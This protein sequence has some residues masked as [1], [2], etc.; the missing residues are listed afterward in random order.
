[1]RQCILPYFF[2][3][4]LWCVSGLASAQTLSPQQLV[5]EW[6]GFQKADDNEKNFR[7]ASLL[8]G[9][10]DV[11]Q[12]QYLDSIPVTFLPGWR[13]AKAS[14]NA[15]G[16]FYA[17]VPGEIQPARLL[18]GYLHPGRNEA[19]VF[20]RKLKRATYPDSL[21]V[22]VQANQDTE[23]DYSLTF[24]SG[25]EIL[26]EIPDV[27]MFV[28]SERL[29]RN[30]D[31]VRKKELSDSLAIK[32]MGLMA[33]PQWFGSSFPGFEKLSTVVSADGVL[34]LV[35]WNVEDRMGNHSFYGVA[36][37]KQDGLIK[38]F[39]L[40]D[41]RDQVR[42][43]EYSTLDPGRWYG[44][45]YYTI[46]T[47]RYKGD[48][49]YTLL[50]YNGNDA[51]SRIRVVEVVTLSDDGEPRF[52]APIFETGGRNW[53]RMIFEYSNQASMVLRY[54]ERSKVIV[55]DHL[56]P[57]EPGYQGN[58]KYYGPDLSLDALTFKKG[59]WVLS[60]DVDFRNR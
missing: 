39:R 27:E 51:F 19:L 41:H 20:W 7:M 45:L 37:V 55:M 3:G 49:F 53:R 56:A 1:M 48:A 21:Q 10:E 47:T 6:T 15:F 57:M 32:A 11:M 30:R 34:K 22:S 35:T 5:D 59:V 40:N 14:N 23:A 9:M 52:G 18:Y 4:F 58:R 24:R 28:L 13:V 17:L 44:A 42:S 50:G 54:D 16:V 46:V 36:G 60:Q 2:A 26:L 25:S 29:S 38:V 43:P 8:S 33:Q 31:D 12:N